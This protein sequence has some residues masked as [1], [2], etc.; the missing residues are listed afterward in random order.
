MAKS[1]SLIVDDESD[2][3]RLLADILGRGGYHVRPA[4]QPKLALE[5]VIAAPPVLILL[6]VRMPGMDGFE[7][8]RQRCPGE[9]VR[10]RQP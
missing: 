6:D 8:S 1:K 9:D 3:L 4:D 10:L 5:S 7:L 2:S